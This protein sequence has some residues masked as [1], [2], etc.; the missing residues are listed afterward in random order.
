MNTK[1]GVAL[2]VSGPSGVGKTT[3]CKKLLESEPNLVFSVSCTTR[4]PRTGETDGLDYHFLDKEMFKKKV[5]AGGF[6]EWA[7]VHGNFYGT[8]VSEVENCVTA[9]KD[10][11]LDIDVQGAKQ[12]LAKTQ[13]T[14]LGTLSTT[15]FI[16]PPSVDEMEK[17]LR[18][19]GT[20]ADEVIARRL[21]NSKMELKSWNI[22]QR[23]IV[24]DDLDVA[25]KEFRAVL[26]SERLRIEQF[27]VSGNPWGLVD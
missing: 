19:R 24:N 26:C 4:T 16:G 15:V 13:G 1:Y 12:V 6:L 8:L 21:H 3:L 22:Y 18:G 14:L 9:G 7:E 17:R 10:V 27:K 25:V 5:N 23:L 11:L 2:I 20:D